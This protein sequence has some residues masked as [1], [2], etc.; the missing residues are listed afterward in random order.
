M[1]RGRSTT[2]WSLS[3]EEFG[4]LLELA[5]QESLQDGHA[6]GVLLM[7]LEGLSPKEVCRLQCP[8]N[9]QDPV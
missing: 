6:V 8:R 7:L 3:Y 4:R 9:H 2:S 1:P 5:K